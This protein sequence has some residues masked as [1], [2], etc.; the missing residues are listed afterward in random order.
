MK[1]GESVMATTFGAPLDDEDVKQQQTANGPNG[2]PVPSDEPQ[3]LIDPND[4]ALVSEDLAANPDADAYAAPAP[5]P[6]GKYRV[7]LKLIRSKDS[8]GQEVDYLP[9]LWGKNQPQKVYV[10][11]VQAS[12]ID[13][14]GK[15]DNLSA[16]DYNVSTFIGRDS[17]TKV[18]T[19]VSKL[20][21]ADG[22]PWVPPHTRMSPKAWMETLVKALA[23][24]PEAGIESQWEYSCQECGKAA[25]KAGTDYPRSVTGMHKFPEEKDRTKRAA[26]QAYS[27]EMKCDR[28]PAH[29]YGRARITIARFLS[30]DELKK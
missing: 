28:V 19:I 4:P 21:K 7:K 5:P 27:P 14:S 6:D 24:E 11:A 9:K 16:Y 15:Y 22:S 13:P 23:A 29:G 25:K 3:D 26:G 10:A 17:A 1:E 18:T 8:A 12:I 30:L 2:A 20:R